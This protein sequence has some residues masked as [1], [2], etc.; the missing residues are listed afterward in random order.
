MDVDSLNAF[1]AKINGFLTSESKLWEEDGKLQ[2]EIGISHDF[3]EWQNRL[4][5]SNRLLLL[6][7]M[8]WIAFISQLI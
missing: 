3:T 4:K 7:H 2:G 8:V 6:F 5:E 1:K